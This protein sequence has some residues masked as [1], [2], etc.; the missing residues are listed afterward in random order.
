MA[1]LSFN[2]FLVFANSSSYWRENIVHY[3][4]HGQVLQPLARSK[5]AARSKVLEIHAENQPQQ[6]YGHAHRHR[7]ADAPGAVVLLAVVVVARQHRSAEVRLRRRRLRAL[8]HR[9]VIEQRVIERVAGCAS[10]AA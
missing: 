6:Q 3:K 4:L 10:A 5:Q 2:K 8:H 7:H 9:V 1:N